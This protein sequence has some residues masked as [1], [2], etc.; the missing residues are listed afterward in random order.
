LSGPLVRGAMGEEDISA[1][2][3]ASA[4]AAAPHNDVVEK[5]DSRR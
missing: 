1:V 5:A 2:H 3:A 4:P